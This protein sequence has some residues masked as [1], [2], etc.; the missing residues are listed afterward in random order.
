[1]FAEHFGGAAAAQAPTPQQWWLLYGLPAAWDGRGIALVQS[2]LKEAGVCFKG[3]GNKWEAA[4]RTMRPGASRIL[5]GVSE[6][7]LGIRVLARGAGHGLRSTARIQEHPCPLQQGCSS[8]A[9]LGD[10]AQAQGGR[11]WLSL[12]ILCQQQG[13]AVLTPDV[14]TT[15]H[16]PNRGSTNPTDPPV[17]SLRNSITMETHSPAARQSEGGHF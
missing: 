17:P 3:R 10:A 14:N 11:S 1:M 6:E 4:G 13:C 2:P 16:L 7:E 9:I 5:V 12:R 15:S 8:P